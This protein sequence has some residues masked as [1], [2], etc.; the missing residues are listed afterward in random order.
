MKKKYVNNL[1]LL[2]MTASKGNKLYMLKDY[3]V[4]EA[5]KIL[6][7]QARAGLYNGYLDFTNVTKAKRL[8]KQLEKQKLQVSVDIGLGYQHIEVS[9]S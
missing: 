8:A 3:T 1:M 6:K 2:R 7:I 5:V 4:E 9:W